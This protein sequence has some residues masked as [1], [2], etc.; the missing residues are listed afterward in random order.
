MDNIACCIINVYSVLYTDPKVYNMLLPWCSLNVMF[1]KCE[2]S[3]FRNLADMVK[4]VDTPMQY[5]SKMTA[6]DVKYRVKDFEKA[7]E[8]S[9]SVFNCNVL[10]MHVRYTFLLGKDYQLETRAK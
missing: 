7:L 5:R 4:W 1:T 6:E 2:E 10:F 3:L 9:A 8:V